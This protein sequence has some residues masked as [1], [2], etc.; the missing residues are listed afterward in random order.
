MK[1]NWILLIVLLLAMVSSCRKTDEPELAGAFSTSALPVFAKDTSGDLNISAVDPASFTGRFSVDLFFKTGTPPQKMDIAVI[2]NGNNS[3][4]KIL[5]AD[6][7]Q[8]PSTITVTGEQLASLFS[9][10]IVVGDYFDI[11][12]NI[13]LQSGQYFE[14]FPA[15]GLPYGSNVNQQSGGINLTIRYAALCVFDAASFAGDF[16]VVQDD[17]ADYQPGDVVHVSQV[18]DTH[19]SFKYAAPDAPAIVIAVDATTNATSVARQ[20]IG[21]YGD[22]GDYNVQTVNGD[23][24]NYVAPCNGTL[25][26]TLDFF[27][28]PNELGVGKLKLQKK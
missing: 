11:G 3:S 5:Q 16:E 22:G 20:P 7:T 13:M 6:V 17:W 19:I 23:A 27:D 24:G 28:G 25:S 14:A 2:K 26:L 21:D 8:F 15:V 12:A 9:T 1:H 4:A 18:D 10:P